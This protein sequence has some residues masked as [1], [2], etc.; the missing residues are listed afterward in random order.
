MNKKI[1]QARLDMSIVLGEYRIKLDTYLR[2]NIDFSFVSDVSCDGVSIQCYD[3]L[4]ENIL[5]DIMWE[6]FLELN[7]YE[8]VYSPK[9]NLVYIKYNFSHAKSP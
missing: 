7:T 5:E 6:F 4:P 1:N 8:E 3:I 2:K 9:R